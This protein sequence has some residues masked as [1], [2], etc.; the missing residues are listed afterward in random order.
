MVAAVLAAPHGYLSRMRAG[1][2]RGVFLNKAEDS[3]TLAAASRIAARL[4][5]AYAF[6]SAGSARTGE[7]RRLA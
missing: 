7:A 4:M 2:R 6:V 1:A 5:P 3:A